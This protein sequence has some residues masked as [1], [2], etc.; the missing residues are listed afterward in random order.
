MTSTPTTEVAIIGGGAMGA[1]T[2]YYLAKAG[3]RSTIIE[4]EGIGN[5]RHPATTPAVSTRSPATDCPAH[6]PTS[7]MSPSICTPTSRRPS[8]TNP[9]SHTTTRPSPSSPSHSTT[10]TSP[11]C[12]RPTTP[13]SQPTTASH[14]TGSTQPTSA[15]ME[16]RLNPEA[17]RGLYTHGHCSLSGYEFTL[18]LARAAERMGAEILQAG[19]RQYPASRPTA[20][21]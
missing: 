17:Q 9:A 8:K 11:K 12:T 7:P 21:A 15:S 2:A 13:S 18:A 3:I 10:P 20:T 14:P 16:P 19:Q 5:H 1:S 6:S 4:S